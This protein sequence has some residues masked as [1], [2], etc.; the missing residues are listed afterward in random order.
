METY[1]VNL[2]TLRNAREMALEF[3]RSY[4]NTEVDGWGCEIDLR[5]SLEEDLHLDRELEMEI[6]LNE[7]LDRY[8]IPVEEQVSSLEDRVFPIIRLMI[9]IPL[10]P[11]MVGWIVCRMIWENFKGPRQKPLSTRAK[12]R[13]NHHQITVG[14]LAAS[15]VADRWVKREAVKIELARR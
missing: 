15:L 8:F 5:T 9:G 4:L 6:F 12:I 1:Q 3:T 7:F 13:R 2:A 14:D 10:F 11:L